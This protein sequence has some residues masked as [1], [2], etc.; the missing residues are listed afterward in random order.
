MQPLT[1]CGGI[2]AAFFT[3]KGLWSPR[4]TVACSPARWDDDMEQRADAAS[5]GFRPRWILCSLGVLL[6]NSNQQIPTGLPD[7]GQ[8]QQYRG[9]G[10]L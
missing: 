9:R 2:C 8:Y 10:V 4:S 7:F 3:R 1:R 6:G 5:I